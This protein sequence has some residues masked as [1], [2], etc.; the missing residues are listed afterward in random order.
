MAD[1][2]N[3][4]AD[5]VAALA[6]TWGRLQELARS[7]PAERWTAASDLPD[8][9][10]RDVLAHLVGVESLLLGRPVPADAPPVDVDHP[11]LLVNLQWIGWYR[12]QPVQRALTDFVE[13]T[14]ARLAMLQSATTADFDQPSW[15]PAGP[16]TVRDLLPFRA[17][18]S[19][20][21]EQDIRDALDIPGGW[22]GPAAH[23]AVA[24]MRKS[25]GFAVGKKVAPPDGTVIGFE[26]V[27]PFAQSFALSIDN[28]RANEVTPSNAATVQ[29]TMP[30][31]VFVHLTTGRGEAHA[32][33]DGPV[34]VSGDVALGTRVIDAMNVLF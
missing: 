8:W 16:G 9:D 26:L 19:W 13:V 22:E 15:T 24:R 14:D 4:D 27:G 31:S 3:P 28:G 11:I 7:V 17:F 10:A 23:A 21:H 34:V 33:A 29:L 6:D 30:T 2:T 1:V 32:I 18:D 12:T 25:M 5:L 20:V